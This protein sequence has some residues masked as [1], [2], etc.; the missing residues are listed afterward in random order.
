VLDPSDADDRPKPPPLVKPGAGP[1]AERHEVVRC[2]HCDAPLRLP[3]SHEGKSIRCPACK[4]VF[5]P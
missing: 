2:P 1:R 3:P 4:H 5:K